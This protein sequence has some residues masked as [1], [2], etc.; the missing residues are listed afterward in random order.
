YFINGKTKLYNDL[1]SDLKGSFNQGMESI[2]TLDNNKVFFGTNNGLFL[3]SPSENKNDI[4]FPTE[5]SQITYFRNQKPQLVEI[6]SKDNNVQLPNRTDILRFQYSSPKM[7]SSTLINY[8]YKLENI[9]EDWSPWQK[10]SIKEYTHL[11]PGNYTF[12][13]KS[14]NLAGLLGKE[15]SFKFTILPKWYQ[16]NLAYFLYIITFGFLAYY[17]T[18]YV[19][20]KIAYERRKLKIE[21]KKSQQLLELEI[22]KL[23]LEQDKESIYKDKLILEGDIINKSKEL[24][25]Y[26]I[27]LSKK[28]EVFDEL[29]NDLTKLR[30]LLK[31]QESRKKITEIFQKLNQHRIGEEYIEIFDVN[32]EKIN[33]DFF[34][35]LKQLDPTITKRELRLCAFVKMD[36]TNKEIAPLLNISARGVETSRYR[37]R[38]KLNVQQEDNFITFLENLI[39]KEQE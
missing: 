12:Y 39:E 21:I 19:R 33:H 4:V 11:R 15:T 1:F 5:I 37:V 13:V 27:S 30:E 26:T 28:K 32:F 38:K 2:Y 25:N 14:K 9:E 35:K 23:K 17:L 6:N 31:S 3:Y 36:L 34:E 20:R 18:D 16:T 7:F 10:N 8:S 29:R 24:A 22:E